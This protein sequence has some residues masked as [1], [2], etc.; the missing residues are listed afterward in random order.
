MSEPSNDPDVSR[1]YA[2]VGVCA[3][4]YSALELHVQFLLSFLHMGKELAIETV[5]FSRNSSLAQKTKLVRELLQFRIISDPA[6][7]NRGLQLVAEIEAKRKQRN[8]CIHGFWL[9]NRHLL[10]SGIVRVSD[11]SWKYDEKKIEYRALGS[12]DITLTE[13][14][15]IPKSINMLIDRMHAFIRDA[16]IYL[17]KSRAEKSKPAPK[18]KPDE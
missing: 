4:K 18:E 14:E 7:L 2:W 13:L 6:L 17:K 1:A 16:K 10:M 8:L 11:T 15:E 3:I 5:I 9:I 12:Q